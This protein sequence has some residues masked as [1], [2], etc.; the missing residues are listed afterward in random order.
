MIQR[1]LLAAAITV[2]AATPG[3]ERQAE[4]YV[5]P[6]VTTEDHAPEMLDAAAV[7]VA[8]EFT[9][10]RDFGEVATGAVLEHAFRW[11]NETAVE[12]RVQR[13]HAGCRCVAPT[14][15]VDRVAPGGSLPIALRVDTLG[16]DGARR[17]HADVEL[18]DAAGSTRTGRFAVTWRTVEYILSSPRPLRITDIGPGEVKALALALKSRDATPFRVL[19][20]RTSAVGVAIDLP[21]GAAAAAIDHSL[22]VTVRGVTPPGRSG[23]LLE[24]ETDE[25]RQAR[26]R[27][28]IELEFTPAWG[29]APAGS[30]SFGKVAAGERPSR[31]VQVAPRRPGADFALDKATLVPKRVDEPL[32]FL[33]VAAAAT[34]PGRFE[35]RIAVVAD[36]PRSHF[37]CDLEVTTNDPVTPTQRVAVFGVLADRR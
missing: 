36:P 33:T 35:V 30:V 29:F 11:T 34:D 13:V 31:T 15:A 20:A 18:I 21:A 16:Y 32:D 5:A 9:G 3:C 17:S 4:P 24:I 37:F 19:A 1:A 10:R 14:V 7:S 8:G 6:A 22:T 27:L 26:L 28:P 2:A 23:A 12:W 25:P